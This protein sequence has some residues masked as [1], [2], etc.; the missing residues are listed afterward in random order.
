MATT[1]S[2]RAFIGILGGSMA[3]ATA[4]TMGLGAAFGQVTDEQAPETQAGGI[5]YKVLVNKQHALPEGWEDEVELVS[6]TN[7]ENWGGEVEVKTYEAYLALK[8][9]LEADGVF[10]DLDSAYRSVESQQ[11]VWDDF[12][13]D[14]GEEYTKQHVAVPGYSEHHTGLALD[15]FLILDGKAVY[16]NEEMVQHPDVWEK[17]HAKLADHG[18]ILRLLPG[19]K[20]QTG[21]S[22]EPWHIR[23]LDDPDLARE[24]T[25]AGITYEKY[26]GELDPAIAECEVDYGTSELFEESDLDAALDPILD[27]FLS[28]KGCVLHKL[29]F[30]DDKT[31]ADDLAYVNELREA[32]IPEHPEFDQAVVFTSSFHSPSGKDAKGTAW[33]PDT[34]YNDYTWHLGRTGADGSWQ[35]LSWGYA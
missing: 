14:Y 10:I 27:E 2:R 33:E 3:A 18:F 1:L 34:D 19:M 25:E 11:R 31:C 24:I 22:Y 16:L 13:K 28:W 23:Y 5:D 8:Q 21:F 29:A 12:T 17:I 7:S 6:F 9:D 26:L 4:S 15:L 32:K 30:T 20:I 35:L